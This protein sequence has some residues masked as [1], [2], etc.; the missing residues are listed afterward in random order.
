MLHLPD[1]TDSLV[2]TGL[3]SPEMPSHN[4]GPD[5]EPD[6]TTLVHVATTLIVRTNH[7]NR[8]MG[9]ADIDPFIPSEAG[10]RKSA[11]AH[12]YLHRDARGLRKAISGRP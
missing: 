6:A 8:S 12:D 11:F 2:A 10:H 1:I 5:S 9:R 7:V 4:W 3:T